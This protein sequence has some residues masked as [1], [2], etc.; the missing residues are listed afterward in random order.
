MSAVD[1]YGFDLVAVSADHR[2]AVRL[3]FPHECT[4]GDEVRG[5]WSRWWRRRAWPAD[6]PLIHLT[7]HVDASTYVWAAGM[8]LLVSALTLDGQLV[9][10]PTDAGRSARR[11][12]SVMSR[13]T[14]LRDRRVSGTIISKP[15][16][17]PGYTCSSVVI[18]AA[19]RRDAYA[20]SSSRNTS[21]EPTPI[22]A[23]GRPGDVVDPRRRPRT[24]GRRRCRRARRGRRA[25]PGRWPPGSTPA[26][27]RC[28]STRVVFRSSIIG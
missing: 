21:S 28:G 23:G 9:D 12:A 17:A 25:S 5:R 3:A 16:G 4:T 18:P 11:S 24:P 26:R 7:R 19:S 15:C 27:P 20:M 22:H 13:S 1:R 14:R 2:T 6:P 10:A 8:V